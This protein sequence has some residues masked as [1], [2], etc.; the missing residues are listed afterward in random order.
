MEEKIAREGRALFYIP[1]SSSYIRKDGKIEPSW[2]PVF[3]NPYSAI[4]R[5]MTILGL[6]AYQKM[7]ERTRTFVEPL[8]G[9]CV[10]SIR[11]LL[12]TLSDDIFAY[13][14]DIDSLA[15][16][17][18]R[19][20]AELNNAQTRLFSERSDAR[21][22]MLKLD[23]DQVP[24]DSVDIDPYGSPIYYFDSAIKSIGKR[25]FVSLTATDLGALT[26]RYGDTALRRYGAR[27]YETQFSKEVGARV[28]IGSFVRAA[29]YLE[30]EVEPLFVFYREHFIKALFR[31]ERSKSG[32][33]NAAKRL[34]F[35]CINE[36]GALTSAIPL[37]DVPEGGCKKMVGPLWIGKMWN[38]D[39]VLLMK[40]ESIAHDGI[41]PETSAAISSIMGEMDIEAL[42]YY[43]VDEICS[44]LKVN[45]PR[46]QK[47]IEALKQMGYSASRTHFDRKGIRTNAPISDV[48]RAIIS[49]SGKS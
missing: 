5:D 34:G 17:Y 4:N 49:S 6:R 29:S 35:L 18:C 2:M 14:S 33:V 21:L 43:R 3:Y 13:A 12:E 40:E 9:I 47:L 8:S 24:V 10:R 30:R 20:N 37:G 48:K 32:S 11:V 36:E 16:D 39:F 31:V 42:G 1:I 44:S 45:V 28:L 46:F 22:F 41:L 38:R 27:I 25:A 19:R 7:G 23:S 15:I 26:G